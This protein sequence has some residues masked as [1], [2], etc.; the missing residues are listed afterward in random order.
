MIYQ[1]RATCL[2]VVDGDT[3]DF[4]I[5]LGLE[6]SHRIRVRLYGIN[7]PE[8]HSPDDAE[9][10][11]AVLARAFLSTM[12]FGKPLIVETIK[13]RTEKYG[14]YLADVFVEGVE[15]SVN[16]QLLEAGLAVEYL[17]KEGR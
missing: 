12:I 6:I 2:A 10:I 17:P 8:L 5:D 11:K 16:A 9:R 4:E 1:Y 14:R 7:T 13:D 15:K 3:A